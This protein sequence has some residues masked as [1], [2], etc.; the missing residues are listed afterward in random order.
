MTVVAYSTYVLHVVL[1]ICKQTSQAKAILISLK[2]PNYM[3]NIDQRLEKIKC[4]IQANHGIFDTQFAA[5]GTLTLLKLTLFK[6]FCLT[7]LHLTLPA[8][9]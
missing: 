8:L 7:I 5:S 6:Y 9:R 4:N 3:N 2:T 1:V